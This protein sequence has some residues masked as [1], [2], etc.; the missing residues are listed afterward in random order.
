MT[1]ESDFLFGT[2]DRGSTVKFTAPG[3][4][5]AAASSSALSATEEVNATLYA[6]MRAARC[7]PVLVR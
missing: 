2:D 6:R 5:R 4:C 7:D 1:F 3:S